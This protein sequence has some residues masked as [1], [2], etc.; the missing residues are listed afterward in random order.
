MQ[1]YWL[2]RNDFSPPKPSAE[3]TVQWTNSDTPN[4]KSSLTSPTAT[5]VK[6]NSVS[7]SEPEDNR[8]CLSR[9]GSIRRDTPPPSMTPT[10]VD[11]VDLDNQ[12]ST[13]KTLAFK[14]NLQLLKSSS[15]HSNSTEAPG[16]TQP[17]VVHNVP[18]STTQNAQPSRN[19]SSAGTSQPK[20]AAVEPSPI[21]P[22]P[23]GNEEKTP[24]KF[25][26][27]GKEPGSTQSLMVKGNN[28]CSAAC[29]LL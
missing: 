13:D 16:S 1:T 26:P 28:G 18:Q 25:A 23:V 22:F 5:K 2:T 29:V 20:V 8:E 7:I 10:S 9:R 11:S 12:L 6:K 19:L 21:K 27:A 4:L 17:I 15:K 14:E 24:A 3:P